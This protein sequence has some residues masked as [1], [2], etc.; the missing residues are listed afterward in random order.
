MTKYIALLIVLTG[1]TLFPLGLMS[2]AWGF[3]SFVVWDTIPITW[4]FVR[5]GLGLGVVLS[6]AVVCDKNF[7]EIFKE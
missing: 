7:R 4:G 6:V 1:T 3:A 2:L 5:V